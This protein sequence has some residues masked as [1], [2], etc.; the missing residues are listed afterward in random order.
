MK[1][2][3]NIVITTTTLALLATA[4]TLFSVRDVQAA[5]GAPK[6]VPAGCMSFHLMCGDFSNPGYR[7]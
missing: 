1:R 4:V 2:I 3:K 6:E 5:T 7:I